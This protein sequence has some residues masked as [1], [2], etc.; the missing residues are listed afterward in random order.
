MKLNRKSSVLAGAIG[1]VVVALLAVHRLKTPSPPQIE[2]SKQTT[3]LSSQAPAITPQVGL[4][5][6]VSPVITH[7]Q[8]KLPRSF[9]GRPIVTAGKSILKTR[10][11]RSPAYSTDG[12]RNLAFSGRRFVWRP[13]YAAIPSDHRLPSTGSVIAQMSGFTLIRD[14]NIKPSEKLLVPG[15]NGYLPVAENS[16][17]GRLGVVTG[18]LIVQLS[19][20]PDCAVLVRNYGMEIVSSAPQINICFMRSNPSTD[21]RAQLKILQADLTITKAE[22]EIIDHQFKPE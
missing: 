15:R 10:A 5:P 13:E 11:H 19:S 17:T 22:I 12:P 2:L 21:L 6:A 20:N 16:S 1:L 9:S 3:P 4:P 14:K 8:K 18:T 7:Q